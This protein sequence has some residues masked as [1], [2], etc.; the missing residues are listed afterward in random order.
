MHISLPRSFFLVSDGRA[1][2]IIRA[3]MLVDPFE[4]PEGKVRL[5]F[6]A[7]RLIAIAVVVIVSAVSTW[8]VG[9]KMRR[10]I[11][12]DLG[13]KASDL[14]LTSLDTWME[15]DDEEQRN[16]RNIPKKPD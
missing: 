4:T 15:V 7:L 11:K 13:R 2:S 1:R 14:D 6:G 3:T 10:R 12:R 16:E 9:V 8:I 5:Y